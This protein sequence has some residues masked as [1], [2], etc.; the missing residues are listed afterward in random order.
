MSTSG[1]F[2]LSLFMSA[3]IHKIVRLDARKA[4]PLEPIFSKWLA[5]NIDHLS[6][7]IGFEITIEQTEKDVGP[8]HVDLYGEDEFGNMLIIENQ[9]EKTDHDHLGKLLVY[10]INLEAKR[11]VWITT[12][13]VEQH[14]AV[15]DWLNENTPEDIA[16]YLIKVEL[17]QLENNEPVAPLFT[18]IKRPTEDAKSIGQAKKEYAK[19]QYQKK[20]FWTGLLEKEREMTD[21]HANI[22][23]GYHNWIGTS[24]GVNGINYNFTINNNSSGFELYIDKG[25]GQKELNKQ[26]FDKLHAHKEDIEAEF[27]G[28]FKWERL[29]DKRACRISYRL[30]NQGL[31]D[32]DKWDDTQEKMIDGMIRFEK[33]IKKHIKNLK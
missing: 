7:A 20:E 10:A 4:W 28:P 33:A 24:A 11:V 13:P 15:I 30:E 26:R 32:E 21:L 9:L 16:F 25:K 2:N 19:S 8:F 12:N 1:R 27:G 23:P 3:P 31:L 18:V 5:E 22:S 14:A 6:E 29:D 17:I